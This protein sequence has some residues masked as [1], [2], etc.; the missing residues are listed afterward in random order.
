MFRSVLMYVKI[1]MVFLKMRIFTV[2]RERA[3]TKQAKILIDH[4]NVRTNS[5]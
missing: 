4:F 1:R 3:S 5:A 2:F